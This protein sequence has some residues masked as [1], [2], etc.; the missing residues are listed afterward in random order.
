MA[1]FPR[2]DKSNSKKA[3]KKGAW[4][5]E[6]DQKLVAYIKKYGIWNWT[7]MAEPAGLART[8]K[9]CRLRWM[10]YLRPNI[11]HGNI[12]KEEEEIIINLHRVL[13]NRWASIASRLPGRTDNEIKNYWN[14][15]L[16]KRC[17]IENLEMPTA[18]DVKVNSNHNDPLSCQD[19]SISLIDATKAQNLGPPS[20]IDRVDETLVNGL[21][22]PANKIDKV[23][24][25]WE[26][27]VA[28]KDLCIFED[29]D[30]TCSNSGTASP[31]SKYMYS[32]PIY[33][34][35]SY[36]DFVIDLWGN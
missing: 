28:L 35:E 16:K 18:C 11:K 25:I 6:E 10:N 21:I 5:A 26:Q 14:I 1:R 29:F 17:L 7:H 24:N 3:V 19:S 9:S 31:A 2:V 36:E 20:G 12:T 34:G 8:G 30:G 15:C 32:E 27:L 4:S 13:G 22:S 23:E 33:F